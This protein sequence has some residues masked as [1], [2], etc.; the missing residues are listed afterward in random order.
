MIKVTYDP[1]SPV[2]EVA[3]HAGT[4]EY[5]RDLVCAAASILTQTLSEAVRNDAECFLPTVYVTN[6]KARVACNAQLG[7]RKRCREVFNTI[8]TGYELL[9]GL[10]PDV[11]RTEFRTSEEDDA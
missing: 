1:S 5:G 3:G 4:A 9:A 7:H 8:F 10:Y 11:I 2:M 6:G